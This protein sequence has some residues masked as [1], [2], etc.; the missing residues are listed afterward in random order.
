MV[1][2]AHLFSC[3]SVVTTTTTTVAAEEFVFGAFLYIAL[4]TNDRI[5]QTTNVYDIRICRE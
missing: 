5:T 4:T 1:E 3:L 2:A